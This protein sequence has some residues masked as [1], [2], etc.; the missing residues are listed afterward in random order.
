MAV[1]LPSASQLRHRVRIE[2]RT[3]VSDGRGTV[4]GAWQVV[5]SGIPARIAAVRGGEQTRANRRAG[6]SEFDIT[7]RSSEATRAITTADRLVNEA[8][9]Q[10]FN[11]QW[12]ANLD[13]QDRFI[14]IT[15]EHGGLD[16]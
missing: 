7:V 9:G 14:T 6:I 2:R 4:S 11:V 16:D 13:E 12:S 15:A 1:Q 10:T 8:T 3:L 5:A